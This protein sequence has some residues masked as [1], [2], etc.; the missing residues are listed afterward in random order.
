[1]NDKFGILSVGA[2]IPRRRLQRNIIHQANSWFA[3]NLRGLARGEKAIVNWDEDSVTMAVDAGRDCLAACGDIDVH[4]I[5]FAST[6]L[7]FADRLN[8]GII[9]EAMNLSNECGR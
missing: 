5:S 1:M 6:T 2:Y 9:K 4:S 8:A 3:P 7:P